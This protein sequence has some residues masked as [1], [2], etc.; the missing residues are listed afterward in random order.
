MGESPIGER[1]QQQHAADSNNKKKG[2]HNLDVVA[3]HG[4]TEEKP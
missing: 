2:G 3:N 4:F 1:P